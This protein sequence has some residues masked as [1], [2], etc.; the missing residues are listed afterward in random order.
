MFPREAYS[1]LPPSLID[2]IS[3]VSPRIVVITTIQMF[4]IL[5]VGAES[6][7]VSTLLGGPARFFHC[8]VISVPHPIPAWVSHKYLPPVPFL[9]SAITD[10]P[11]FWWSQFLSAS[12]REDNFGLSLKLYFVLQD[13]ANI[14]VE[15][16]RLVPADFIIQGGLRYMTALILEIR[17]PT[18]KVDKSAVF[19][20]EL[21]GMLEAYTMFMFPKDLRYNLYIQNLPLLCTS[22]TSFYKEECENETHNLISL[23]AEARGETPSAAWWNEGVHSSYEIFTKG[24]LAFHLDTT[25]Y[26]LCELNL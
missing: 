19:L 16:P 10:D 24:Y 26:R 23:L 9:T 20:R 4:A 21:S 12:M 11:S 2:K 25:R 14:L 8:E 13:F 3:C 5:E 1:P 17:E 15:T 6:M 7:D 22:R 18:H